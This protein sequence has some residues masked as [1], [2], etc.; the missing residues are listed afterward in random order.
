MGGCGEARLKSPISCN[1]RTHQVLLSSIIYWVNPRRDTWRRT[2]DLVVV[3]G[4]M[5][6]HVCIGIR[7]C[8]PQGVL[9]L[10]RLCRE[11]GRYGRPARQRGS[12]R[13]VGRGWPEHGAA[14]GM[15]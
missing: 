10:S 9:L 11:Q 2:L 12:K 5:A 8:R 3:R 1:P 4:G 7:F 14:R 15:I 13:L 6:S